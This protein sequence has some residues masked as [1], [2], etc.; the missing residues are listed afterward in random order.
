MTATQLQLQP[1]GGVT[2]RS[3]WTAQEPTSDQSP[4]R[5]ALRFAVK[6]GQAVLENFAVPI[7]DWQSTLKDFW[8]G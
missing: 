8:V 2:G 4:T 1:T 3:V 7:N 5:A 6:L